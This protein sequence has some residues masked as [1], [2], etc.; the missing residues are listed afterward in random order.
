MNKK[1]LESSFRNVDL[2]PE[3]ILTTDPKHVEDHPELKIPLLH[4]DVDAYRPIAA[5]LTERS[6]TRWSHRRSRVL[7][8]LP[9]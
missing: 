4:I 5:V 1:F 8:T 3:D 9:H 6:T 2:I 7:M